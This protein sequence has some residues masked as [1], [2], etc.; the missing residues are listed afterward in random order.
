[1]ALHF[2]VLFSKATMMR[3][4]PILF[5]HH[6]LLSDKVE[7]TVLQQDEWRNGWKD[8]TDFNFNSICCKYRLV[9]PFAL[10]STSSE[11]SHKNGRN[12]LIVTCRVRRDL[13]QVCLI[14]RERDREKIMIDTEHK[15]NWNRLLL[16][17]IFHICYNASSGGDNWH[18]HYKNFWEL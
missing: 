7:K 6:H 17:Y 14:F 8:L 5:S 1:M 13:D 18:F 10:F 12:T 4:K 2:E 3:W 11:Q 9:T 16:L 15:C